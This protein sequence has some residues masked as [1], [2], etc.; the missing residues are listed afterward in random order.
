MFITNNNFGINLEANCCKILIN[1]GKLFRG[2]NFSSFNKEEK[3][4]INI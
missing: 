3:Q 4:L 2:D 1:I